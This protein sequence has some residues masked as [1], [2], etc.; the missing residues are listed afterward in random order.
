VPQLDEPQ[1]YE[2]EPVYAAPVEDHPAPQPEEPT[3]PPGEQDLRRRRSTIREPVT[4][5]GEGMPP[6]PA[7]FASPTPV[8]SSSGPDEQTVP[9]RGWWGRRLLGDKS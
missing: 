4:F 3:A 1:Q 2:S 8:I 5:P 9:K 7:N 6:S